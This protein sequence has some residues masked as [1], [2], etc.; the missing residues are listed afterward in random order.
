MSA[1]ERELRRLGWALDVPAPPDLAARVRAELAPRSRPLARRRWALAV[2]L[3]LVAALVATLAVP[4]AR[5]TL[6]R[7]L[8]IGGERIVRVD[9][10]PPVEAEPAGLRISL[11]EEV[12][13][14]Q[15][16]ARAGFELRGFEDAGAPDRVYLAPRDTV[17]FLWG[18]PRRVRLLLAQT[19]EH[20]V[21][22][23]P[24]FEK[25]VARGT[26][27]E[28]VSVA[29][30][31]GWFLSG[32]PHVV[33]LLGAT[34]E[35]VEETARLAQDVLVWEQDGVTFRLEGALGRERAVELATSL[36]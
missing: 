10:L 6:F 26:T 7:V 15:A 23:P 25:L 24:L 2:A 29:G 31:P 35:I 28:P 13:L 36:R 21:G 5:S 3:V 18:T 30:R 34:G 20:S 4:D 12:T 14:V 33:Y 9:E 8:R 16:R 11:G 1:E 32:A 22:S 19:P 27:V 17:W